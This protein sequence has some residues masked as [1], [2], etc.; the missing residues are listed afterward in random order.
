[1]FLNVKIAYKTNGPETIRTG[2]IVP[3][4]YSTADFYEQ[5]N[6]FWMLS[7]S[8]LVAEFSVSDEDGAVLPK[9]LGW[10]CDKWVKKITY[11]TDYINPEY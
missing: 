10:A 1:M 4:P 3:R 2:C 6:F 9:D 7:Q 8:D 5:Y 11:R